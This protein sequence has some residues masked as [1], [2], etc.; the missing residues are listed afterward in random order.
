[1]R[2]RLAVLII[3]GCLVITL[4]V[5]MLA[6]QQYL[7]QSK[8]VVTI[9]LVMGRRGSSHIPSANGMSETMRHHADSNLISTPQQWGTIQTTN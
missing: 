7:T 4:V 5:L 8:G 9:S 3:L 2:K 6:F 1:M